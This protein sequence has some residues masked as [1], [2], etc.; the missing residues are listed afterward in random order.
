MKLFF[1]YGHDA[2]TPM[3]N[4]LKEDLE[5]HGHEVW[6]DHERIADQSIKTHDSDWRVSITNGI[7]NSDIVLSFASAHALR[8]NGVCLDELKIA[9]FVRG[10][11]V[12]ALLLE[13]EVEGSVPASIS[14]RQYKDLSDWKV[15]SKDGRPEGP[16][17][18]EWY[19]EK[20]EDILATLSKDEVQSYHDD[21]EKLAE[22]L[23]P[24]MNTTKQDELA[25]SKFIGREW[26][27]EK[28]REWEESR[29]QALVISGA[30]GIG[31]SAFV[32]NEF[33]M[34]PSVAAAVFCQFD[35]EGANNID[36]IAATIAY[37]MAARYD[38]YRKALLEVCEKEA[39]A[40]E[41]GTVPRDSGPFERYILSIA[42]RLIDGSREHFVI[43]VDGLD[44]AQSDDG[45][46]SVAKTLASQISRMPK[47]ARF[48]LT[49]RND[50]Y[51]LHQV[52][53]YPKIDLDEFEVEGDEDVSRYVAALIG[54]DHELFGAI[55][56]RGKGNFLYAK[57]ACE[58]IEELEA[59]LPL[60]IELVGFY[61]N[62]MERLRAS[63]AEGETEWR[64]YYDSVRNSLGI[65]A[66][67]E[68]G[69]PKK[70]LC[71]A[72]GWTK[73]ERYRYAEFEEWL[74]MYLLE[75]DERLSFFHKSFADWLSSDDAG[76]Y[77]C[78]PDYAGELLTRACLEAYEEC[79]EDGSFDGMNDYEVFNLIPLLQEN[80]K[81]FK[82]GYRQALSD[83]A[84]FDEL[85]KRGE[86]RKT[87][88]RVRILAKI[89]DSFPDADS[90]VSANGEDWEAIVQQR[91]RVLETLVSSYEGILCG[92][93]A[94]CTQRKLVELM[95]SSMNAHP[96]GESVRRYAAAI[97][98]YAE[99]LSR[100]HLA[101]SDD[102]EAPK[103]IYLEGAREIERLIAVSP[104]IDYA[105][106]ALLDLYD[107][108]VT[109]FR[110]NVEDDEA[111]RDAEAFASK[112]V[113]IAEAMI[114]DRESRRTAWLWRKPLWPAYQQLSEI[115]LG[116]IYGKS[117]DAE[118]ALGVLRKGLDFLQKNLSPDE[119][120]M[121][122]WGLDSSWRL[123][124]HFS[125]F[126]E[127]YGMYPAMMNV[128]ER[129]RNKD[130]MQD[131]CNEQIDLINEISWDSGELPVNAAERVT[132]PFRQYFQFVP[133]E[134]E[135]KAKLIESLESWLIKLDADMDDQKYLR[136]L[137]SD[138]ST[139]RECLAKLLELMGESK[140]E[141]AREEYCYVLQR[142]LE[143]E[144]GERSDPKLTLRINRLYGDIAR[145]VS[146]DEPDETLV[147]L[148]WQA[149]DEAK[150]ALAKDGKSIEDTLVDRGQNW[151]VGK[152]LSDAYR[153]LIDALEDAGDHSQAHR[154]AKEQ[155]ETFERAFERDG[156]SY[157]IS[158]RLLS[159]YDMLA[160]YEAEDMVARAI[161]IF[162]KKVDSCRES[163]I[164]LPSMDI[165]DKLEAL[166]RRTGQW[167]EASKLSLEKLAIAEESDHDNP[168][169]R[170]IEILESTLSH[171]EYLFRMEG[172][173]AAQAFL[174]EQRN[175]SRFYPMIL[176]SDI[177]AHCIDLKMREIARGIEDN[178]FDDP[179]DGYNLIELISEW[180]GVE[181][182]QSEK[183][184][185]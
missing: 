138:S 4:R 71:R 139:P 62:A 90:A 65:I 178:E 150:R 147:E 154:V 134:L 50:A 45:T 85:F 105:Q 29:E 114:R 180:S 117:R 157:V 118:Q 32:V 168:R 100:G 182:P 68:E 34:S 130:L 121:E 46:N 113:E 40:R 42:D 60:P 128:A 64:G 63:I 74:S 20:L 25:Q 112:R 149:L 179:Q 21:L 136:C 127:L 12:Q 175:T 23:N 151:L 30:P 131:L 126:D 174:I 146:K 166:Y 66:T 164:E 1:S 70:T 8:D 95:R 73:A 67:A 86:K 102:R 110:R 27:S 140:R 109:L 6:I 51:V 35:N 39:K 159:A 115:Y 31:K 43:L 106:E 36:A 120:V 108:L 137:R 83:R 165:F 142:F 92:E 152:G 185:S 33:T 135:Y 96:S 169:R 161:A 143:L 93:E 132:A 7:N 177:G 163:K 18:E 104:E 58:H 54:D 116:D 17:F 107:S 57:L 99:M 59:G 141:K 75:E 3:V 172:M 98:E 122:L 69:V 167:E 72:V 84:F 94:I 77:H 15:H 87:V 80:R 19:K 184:G 37:Q 81:E 170:S 158:D 56:E 11:F 160:V 89:A 5:K 38:D 173:A 55:V 156:L 129:I 79:V 16:E 133:N 145:N 125:N 183:T 153:D 9:V 22:Y 24:Y 41:S 2:N 144:K 61:A 97:S 162:Q 181:V 155:A 103:E 76:R 13:P 28:V 124:F 26:L 14:H 47:Y 123:N 101:F 44:E 88:E 53:K 176:E 48:I 148:K 52:A 78:D 10:A 49:T 171:A 91:A 119:L 82:E 111:F